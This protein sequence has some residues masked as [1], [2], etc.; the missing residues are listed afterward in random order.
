[1][2]QLLNDVNMR[3]KK[4]V[5]SSSSLN[6][7]HALETGSFIEEQLRLAALRAT[8]LLDT[9]P[10]DMFDHLTR[11]VCDALNVPI[12]L[13]SLVDAE[14]QWFKSRCGLEAQETPRSVSFCAHAI[15][16]HSMFVV[17]D[18]LADARFVNNALVTGEPHIRFYAGVP[19][20]GTDRQPIGTLCVIDRV[21]RN[22]S[23]AESR[24]LQSLARA[25]QEMIRLRQVALAA[26][27]LLH[28]SGKEDVKTLQSEL[29]LLLTRDP[30]TGLPNRA[31][32]EERIRTS[33]PMW[34][35]QEGLATIVVVNVDN[36]DGINAA[37]TYGGGDQILVELSRLLR[38]A[39]GAEDLISRIGGDTFVALLCDDH[40][41][42][43]LAMRLER[44]RQAAQFGMQIDERQ[45]N[46]TCG[47]G[48]SR[49]P[50]DGDNADA[51]INAACVAV[52]AAKRTG[53]GAL[54]P[55][56]VGSGTKHS[57]YLLESDLGR[58][59]ENSE[60]EL[61]YQPK[62]DLVTQRIIGVEALVRWHHPSRGMVGPA[63]FIPLAEHTGLIVP[64]SAWT[65]DRACAELAHW[66]TLGVD[67]VSMAVNLSSRLFSTAG[68]V[69][70]IADVLRRYRLP[71]C[72]LDLEVTESGS[73]ADPV[74]A[75]HLMRQLKS[76]G[77]TI[78]VD[79]FGTGYSSLS[80]LK[81][82]PVDAIK[83]DRSFVIDMLT[84]EGTLAIMQGM[85]ATA[86]RLGLTIVAEGVETTAQRDLLLREQCD[87]AQGFLYSRPLPS[88]DC[89]ALVRAER[90][91]E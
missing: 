47:I 82:F 48:F 56:R 73:M 29:S 72:M 21:P 69:P 90:K 15:Q 76:L 78:S 9:S 74:L 52:R 80:Y 54:Q 5:L 17:Q 89:L 88:E 6:S 44:L 45:V 55:Y 11:A 70:M 58:A 67:D 62:V 46:V 87:V 18:T 71:G 63:E 4:S 77:A 39:I 25:T 66:R 26:T 81:D 68:L 7:L 16:R 8:G 49:F 84:S 36:F 28:P 14:R 10:E 32:L 83:I 86:R 59:I 33:I 42:N 34:R 60:L 53:R 61:H 51:L 27:A 12:A 20:Y 85:I 30:L 50:V 35:E 19:L 24:I 41:V 13:V 37:L 22:L 23:D 75:A 3:T 64:L 40:G 38:S 1:M 91:A 31:E 79:D 43:D 57:D 2:V 65:I